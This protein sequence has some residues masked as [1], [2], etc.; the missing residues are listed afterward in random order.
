M[1]SVN[2]VTSVE[3]AVALV[4]PRDTIAT[5]GFV[6]NGTPDALIDAVARA[7]E[8]SGTPRDL[9]LVF[10]AGQGDG[11]SRGL[12]RLALPG[13]IRRAVG[14]HWGLI[15]RLGALALAGEI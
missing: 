2:K 5:S 7:F 11:K 6:G 10:A 13:L 3:E 12:N 4:R 14:G 1:L 15:P 8:E 9:T